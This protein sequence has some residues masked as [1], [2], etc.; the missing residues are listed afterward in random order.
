MNKPYIGLDTSEQ[1]LD[2]ASTVGHQG[3]FAYDAPG[4]DRLLE[5][6]RPIEP[7]LVVLEATGGL[8]HEVAAEL[9][10]A[11]LQVAVINPRQVRS[12]RPGDGAPGQDRPHRRPGAGPVC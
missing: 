9:A 10:A 4:I 5:T 1:Y 7:A 12:L 3:R 11:S 8:E 2:V 6:L